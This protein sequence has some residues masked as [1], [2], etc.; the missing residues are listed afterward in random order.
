ML[1]SSLVIGPKLKFMLLAIEK[2]IGNQ[3]L[4][5]N[6]TVLS[7]TID[8]FTL[9]RK[10]APPKYIRI[11]INYYDKTAQLHENIFRKEILH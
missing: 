2:Y 6:Y 3:M 1:L 5:Y 11:M 8:H 7:K 9:I 10:R 4:K